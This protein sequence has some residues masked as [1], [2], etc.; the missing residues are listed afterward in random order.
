MNL[1][2][3]IWLGEQLAD[4]HI[5]LF[6]LVFIPETYLILLFKNYKM[7]NHLRR[8]SRKVKKPVYASRE[9]EQ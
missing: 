1:R 4:S 2:V 8:F 7:L 3:K 6:A 9:M 5:P